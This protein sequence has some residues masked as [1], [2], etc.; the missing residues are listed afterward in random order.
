[1][2]PVAGVLKNLGS[3]HAWVVHGH[4]GL[5]EISTTGPT[6][7]AE[8]RDGSIS[9]FEVKPEDAGLKRVT[10]AELKGGD[11]RANAAT[12]RGLLDGRQGAYRDIVLLNAAAAL[13]VGNIAENLRD[14]AARA[15]QSID[16]GGARKALDG[17][18]AISNKAP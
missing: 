15:A 8:L 2:E 18:I 11:A 6:T 7:V 10:L 3:S 5:D 14:G 9:V 4:D 16:S 12:L 13:I 17:L 1:V